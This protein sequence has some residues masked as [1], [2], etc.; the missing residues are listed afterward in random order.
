M[1]ELFRQRLNLA[2]ANHLVWRNKINKINSIPGV[3]KINLQQG[4]LFARDT[5]TP[6]GDE[7]S[8]RRWLSFCPS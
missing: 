8:L 5:G 1:L 7:K 4:V 6:T 3:W 2:G